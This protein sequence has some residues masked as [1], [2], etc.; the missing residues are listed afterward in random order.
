MMLLLLLSQ[1]YPIVSIVTSSGGPF[2]FVEE[3]PL[4]TYVDCKWGCLL[5]CFFRGRRALKSI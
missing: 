2:F 5:A 1:K 4:R 3:G